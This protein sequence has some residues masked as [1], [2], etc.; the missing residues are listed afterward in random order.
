M[1][2]DAQVTGNELAESKSESGL[3]FQSLD[4]IEIDLIEKANTVWDGRR[5]I[6]VFIVI[7]LAFAYFHSEYGP[8]EYTSTASLIQESEG[9]SVG[10]FGSSFLRSLTGLNFPSGGGSGNMSA[11]ATG[12]APLPVSLYPVIVSS[13]EFQK[14]LIYTELEFSTFNDSTM[15]I[16]DY[17]HDYRE[18]ALRDRV[19][20]LIGNMTIYL[21]VTVL[22]WGKSILKG[23]INGI[24]SLWKEEPPQEFANVEEVEIDQ[25]ERLQ[26]VTSDE[27]AVIEWL[28][29]RISLS[30]AGGIMEITTTFPDPKAAA[31]VNAKLIQYIQDYITD[32]RI[33]K[34]Q[35]NLDNTLER[36][37]EAKERYEEAQYE[38]A[39]YR[40]ENLNVS[41]QTASLEENR[42]QNETSL[43]GSIYNSV[44]QEVEQARMI[45]QQQIPVFNPLEKP[46]VPPY[47]SS[48]SSPLL[49]VFAGVLGLFAGIAWVLIRSTSLFN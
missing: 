3:K 44:A 41:S 12:R 16:F 11:V 49:M 32:Y 1:S 15:T 18:P 46:N 38:L 37:D 28:K 6:I 14:E 10:D 8:T 35:Q 26:S 7:C 47:P 42:L 25:D 17:Y 31:L 36:Y 19:Y 20:T 13:T 27:R 5:T 43:R 34:A 39:Q 29:L 23:V 48:G 22:Q 9:A 2:D 21:P 33:Q 40:D 45:L 30:S 4:I 24:T